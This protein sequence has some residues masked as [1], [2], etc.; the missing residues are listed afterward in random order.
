[1]HLVESINDK[2]IFDFLKH[3]VSKDT[4]VLEWESANRITEIYVACEVTASRVYTLHMYVPEEF[5]Q[6][7][8]LN[9]AKVT[10]FPEV[11][12][13]LCNK[14]RVKTILVNF[15]INNPILFSIAKDL[16]F[17]TKTVTIGIKHI[18]GELSEQ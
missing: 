5:R 11:C 14:Y 7:R 9:K 15:D 17:T 3:L 8:L 16:G 18:G 13:L 1:M 2:H 4:L 10:F 6:R 12:K